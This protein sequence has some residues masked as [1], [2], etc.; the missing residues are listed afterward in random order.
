LLFL[1]SSHP[2]STNIIACDFT[3]LFIF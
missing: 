3:L 2:H 1:S